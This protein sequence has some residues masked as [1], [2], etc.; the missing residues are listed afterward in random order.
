MPVDPGANP[1][2]KAKAI[3]A[4]IFLVVSF[5]I[6]YLVMQA[7]APNPDENNGKSTVKSK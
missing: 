3:G 1:K 5:I 4:I 2:D 6:I 7:T